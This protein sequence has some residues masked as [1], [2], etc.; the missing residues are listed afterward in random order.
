MVEEIGQFNISSG[1]YLLKKYSKSYTVKRVAGRYN[2]YHNEDGFI[3]QAK[4]QRQLR[5]GV[6]AYEE[7][8]IKTIEG[9]E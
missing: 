6:R 4:T 1:L 5:N 3:V 7:Q 8:G 9:R 2:L